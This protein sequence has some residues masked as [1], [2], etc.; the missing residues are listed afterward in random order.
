MSYLKEVP[1]DESTFEPFAGAKREFGFVPNFYK[2]QTLR[3]DIIEAEVRLVES[4][5]IKQGDLERRQKEYIFLVCSA[6]NLNTYCVTAHCEIIRMLG[7]KGPALDKLALNH[8]ATDLPIPDK[9]LLTFALK[10]NNDPM[11]FTEEDV[12]RL[13]PYGFSDQ[14]ILE[15]VL[16]VSLSK[17]A[18]ILALGL[19]ARP[20]FQVPKGMGLPGEGG[21]EQAA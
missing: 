16:M 8:M 7:L 5:V 6:A 20:D 14:A 9:M 13:R 12:A 4:I 11:G 2:A 15:A 18:N 1:L 10:L 19:G 21:G 17:W 3:P